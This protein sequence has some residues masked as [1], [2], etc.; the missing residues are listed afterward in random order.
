MNLFNKLIRH[1][2]I[3]GSSVIFVGWFFGS[4]LNYVFNLIMGRLL[5]VADYGLLVSLSSVAVLSGIFFSTFSSTFAKFA[6]VHHANKNKEGFKDVIV[7]GSKLTIAFSLL[8]LVLMILTKGFVLSF[9]H[10]N[11]SFFLFLIYGVICLNI[12][13]SLPF[14]VFQ[15]QMRFVLLS[16]INGMQAILKLLFGVVL[17]IIGMKTLGALL[18]IFL[19]SLIPTV[20]FFIFILKP[21]IK[22]INLSLLKEQTVSKELTRY[23]TGFFMST[24]GITLLSGTDIILVRH[25][26]DATVSGQYAALSI[27]GKAIFYLIGPIGFVFFPL[28]AYRKEKNENTTSVLLL[29][30]GIVSLFSLALSFIYFVFPN[31]VLSIFFPSAPYKT[32]TSYLGIFSLYIFVFSLASL[33]NSFFLSIGKTSVYKVTLS[34]GILQTILIFVFHSSVYQ[35]IAILFASSFLILAIL[36][37]YYL[38]YIDVLKIIKNKTIASFS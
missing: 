21:Y 1:P 28:I 16:F 38:R 9:L 35:I 12:I 4:F 7:H 3:S 5:S 10:I 24:I 11:N 17:V 20:I 31:L 13:F 37:I 15:G 23:G 32:L 33:F 25:F 2:L 18:G 36:L 27:M 6:A 30:V 26:F 34:V 14:G 29:T 8:L 22:Q 19:S